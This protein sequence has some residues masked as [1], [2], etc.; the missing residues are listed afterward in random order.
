MEIVYDIWNE[1]CSISG[2]EIDGRAVRLSEGRF[3]RLE[4]AEEI[5]Q[6]ATIRTL[7][8]GAKVGH[9]VNLDSL[10]DQ[11]TSCPSQFEGETFD[12][13]H[14]YVRF[15]HGSLRVDVD[16]GTVYI[17]YPPGDGVISLDEVQ[18]HL[19]RNEVGI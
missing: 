14:V 18:R 17:G 1:T 10:V 9:L 7:L 11:G 3:I 5:L 2:K 13:G 19:K 8:E 12:G 6:N 16:G 15:R 4:V